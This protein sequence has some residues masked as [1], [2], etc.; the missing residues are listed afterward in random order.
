MAICETRNPPLT[1]P[2]RGRNEMAICETRNP[3]LSHPGQ[4]VE[5]SYEPVPGKGGVPERSFLAG[6][7]PPDPGRVSDAESAGS[8]NL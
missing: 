6:P 2:G 7:Q 1:H 8:A 5:S 3:P 4:G